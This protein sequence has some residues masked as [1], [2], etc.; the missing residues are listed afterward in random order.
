M[1]VVSKALALLTTL[2]R[3]PDAFTGVLELARED[4]GGLDDRAEG[5]AV[6]W[7]VGE[8]QVDEVGVVETSPEG[9]GADVG[10]L[11]GARA[12]GLR[13]EQ[14]ARLAVGYELQERFLRAGVVGRAVVGLQA[15][16]NDLEASVLG[17]SLG[18]ARLAHVEVEDLED[19]CA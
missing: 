14:S 19:A 9:C 6:G 17:L 7:G 2:L 5:R 13:A 10:E 18:E 11:V 16:A 4:G 1:R 3:S 12:R 15:G 8:V